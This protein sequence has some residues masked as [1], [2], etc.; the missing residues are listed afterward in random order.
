MSSPSLCCAVAT[1]SSIHHELFRQGA[2]QGA[3]PEE[4]HFARCD[5]TTMTA[6][7]I[8]AGRVQ[9]KVGFA[10]LRPAEF[11]LLRVALAAGAIEAPADG[12]LR[13]KCS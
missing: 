3:R 8:A 5:R 4:A 10:P 2:F 13:A 7:E 6:K 9:I 11:V 1:C 12:S